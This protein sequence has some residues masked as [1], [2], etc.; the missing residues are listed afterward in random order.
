[1]MPGTRLRPSLTEDGIRFVFCSLRTYTDLQRGGFSVTLD[2]LLN[3]LLAVV[4][5]GLMALIGGVLA[6]RALPTEP[7]KKNPEM[8]YWIYWFVFLF[9]ISVVLAF[10]Q[11]V[12]NSTQQQLAEQ[13]AA[14]AELKSTGDIKYMQGQLDTT[15]RVLGIVA[16]NSDPKQIASLLQGLLAAQSTLKKDTLAVCSEM[17]QW[18]KERLKTNPF[19]AAA[20][21]TKATPKEMEAQNTYWQK[22]SNDYYVRFGPRVLA[23]VQQYG[24]KGI[25]VKMIE[26][27]AAY[28]SMPN[29]IIIKLRAFAN[30]LDDNGNL[31][32]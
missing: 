12:R 20:D 17:E 30:R 11:Q 15:N 27:Q 19:P 4:V 25:D 2:A 29:D 5:P 21:P 9:L 16:A 6:A 23:I 13:R 28:G 32:E 10:I 1:M 31:K 22:F 18:V 7:G 3:I 26:Q 8:W 24:A 14:Q